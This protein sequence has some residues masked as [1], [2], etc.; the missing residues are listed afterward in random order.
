M[1]WAIP[2]LSQYAFMGWCSVKA[3]VNSVLPVLLCFTLRRAVEQTFCLFRDY[4][5]LCFYISRTV[6]LVLLVSNLHG[7]ALAFGHRRLT[8]QQE[9][10]CGPSAG[11]KTPSIH[12]WQLFMTF[13]LPS[14]LRWRQWLRNV[15]KKLFLQHAELQH[16]K[17]ITYV[18]CIDPEAL[19]LTLKERQKVT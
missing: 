10:K 17:S 1:S 16:I 12:T 11:C 7:F 9:Q 4:L 14:I 19:N 5:S 18:I 3:L 13:T 2:P 15:V 8:F 6:Q